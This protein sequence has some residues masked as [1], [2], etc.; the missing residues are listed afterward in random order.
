VTQPKS[1]GFVDSL[2]QHLGSSTS[3]NVENKFSRFLKQRNVTKWIIS[4][5]FCIDDKARAKDAFAFVIFPAG[6]QLDSTVDRL[7][8]I[9]NRDLKEVRSRPSSQIKRL[10]RKGKVFTFCFLS[11]RA[12]K[13]FVDAAAARTC[14]DNSIS[15][16]E[17][18]E[19]ADQC[20]NIIKQARAMRVEANKNSVSLKLLTHII[21][22]TA[23]VAFIT[24]L[25][26]KHS[27]AA[28]VGWAP[29]RDRITE[30]Y[31]SIASTL[32][33]ANVAALA[34]QMKFEQPKLGVFTQSNENLWCDPYIRIAD[35][36][37]GTG[38]A[39]NPT[40]LELASPKI[41][42]MMKTFADNRYL[43]VFL[44]KFGLDGQNCQTSV[45]RLAIS[46]KP[47]QK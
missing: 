24:G 22:C 25:I 38:A 18:W 45:S 23:L 1:I 14:L 37:A 43:A 13:L 4:T 40:K 2:W 3:K 34:E 31:S 29:D 32:F 44:L 7:A 47:F 27:K 6:D 15:M 39:I 16:M 21:L 8:R 12:N 30:A 41:A 46:R 10:L 17:A 9:P 26:A 28:F 42:S 11:D 20:Q 33:S 5:D 35:F 19:N 36:V